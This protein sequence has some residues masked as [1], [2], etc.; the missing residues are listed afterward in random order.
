MNRNLV[1]LCF[2]TCVAMLIAAIPYFGV[3]Q[4]ASPLIGVVRDAAG[5]PVAGVAVTVLTPDGTVRTVVI[6]GAGGFVIRDVPHGPYTLRAIDEREGRTA[7]LK[8][9]ER[10]LTSTGP[11]LLVLHKSDTK[12]GAIEFSDAPH[13]TVAGVTDW[14][15][16]GGHGSDATLRTSEELTRDTVGLPGHPLKAS[17]V[18][19]AEQTRLHARLAEAPQSYEAN[20]ALGDFYLQAGNFK[21][22]ELLLKTAAALHGGAAQDE[23]AVALTCA[24]LKDFSQAQRHVERALALHDTAEYHLLAGKVDEQLGQSLQAVEHLQRAAVME[25][26]EANYFFWGSEL[27]LHRAIWQAAEVFARGAALYPQSSRMR[28]AWGAALFAGAKYDEAAARLCEASQL[29]PKSRESYVLLGKAALAA[30]EPLACAPEQL[31]IFLKLRP[32]DAEAH[33][34]GA[35][36]LARQGSA[37]N[38]VRAT[39][40]LRTAV[41][42]DPTLA[43]GYL[44]L[45][46]L[47]AAQRHVAESIVLYRQAIKVDIQ[48][49]EAHYRLGLALDRSGQSDEAKHELEIH[50]RLVQTQAQAVEEQ[51]RQVK[52]FV[53]VVP[54]PGE[55]RP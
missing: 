2:K 28:T 34:Y 50:A 55:S 7:E 1:A 52:Q 41:R 31:A 14:T 37:E 15:A 5:A 26:S 38:K 45:G 10:R 20:Q 16:V 9:N 24:G 49:P 27:L 8:V 46:I 19:A 29:D 21:E 39:E 32:D 18:D 23:Y 6:D 4:R 40:M 47:V 11:V 3:A 51:R 36:L 48:L 44:Q 33:F 25:P 13:F 35:M 17:P 42:L 53:V 43:E 22:A 12:G 54:K 30:P